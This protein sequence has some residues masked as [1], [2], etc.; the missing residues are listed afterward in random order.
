[1][2]FFSQFLFN[3]PL[4]RLERNQL[5][6]ARNVPPL[7]PGRGIFRCQRHTE[8]SPSPRWV[9]PLTLA[10]GPVEPEKHIVRTVA[11]VPGCQAHRPCGMSAGE[12][13]QGGSCPRSRGWLLLTQT[14][15]SPC[16]PPRTPSPHAGQP[17]PRLPRS[18][19]LSLRMSRVLLCQQTGC[20]AGQRYQL[21][22]GGT[23]VAGKSPG[24]GAEAQPET[25]AVTSGKLLGIPA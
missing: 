19:W 8:R 4:S 11:G 7:A 22:G 9:V 14:Q 16:P 20:P 13:G 21:G 6:R 24:A 12:G 23:H 25:M 3:I 5:C 18:L 17:L 10:E 15:V 1:M 2:F